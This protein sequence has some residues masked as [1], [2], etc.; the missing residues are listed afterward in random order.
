MCAKVW[1][2]ADAVPPS[3]RWFERCDL[4]GVLRDRSSGQT[5]AWMRTG[6]TRHG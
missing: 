5:A 2:L 4:D 1:D 6:L 3:S